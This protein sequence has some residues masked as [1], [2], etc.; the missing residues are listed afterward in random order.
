MALSDGIGDPLALSNGG[1]HPLSGH[2]PS[3]IRT[4]VSNGQDPLTC[5]PAS[6]CLTAG[7]DEDA[8][9]KLQQQPHAIQRVNRASQNGGVPK[10]NGSLRSL[11]PASA[12][13]SSPAVAVRS[14]LPSAV[15]PSSSSAALCYQHCHFPSAV[16]C[17][18]GRQECPLFQS[19]GPGSVPH[20]GT[21]SSCPCCLSACTY[22]HPHSL[23][24]HHQQRWQEHLQSQTQAPG[25]R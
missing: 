18:C 6:D 12:A 13:S 11:P 25:I 8:A 9:S 22:P 7:G 15:P 1:Q 24:H 19:P 2:A 16:C 3:N 23:H 20:P 5:D 4:A 14:H 17:P 21:G 10:Q